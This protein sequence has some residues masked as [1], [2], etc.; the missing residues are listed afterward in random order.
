MRS[1]G[2]LA[3]QLKAMG[4]SKRAAGKARKSVRHAEERPEKP[5]G[6]PPSRAK[7]EKAAVALAEARDKHMSALKGLEDKRDALDRQIAALKDKHRREIE[8]LQQRRREAEQAYRD[9]LDA[10]SG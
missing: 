3:E 7:V 10:W 2:G 4:P 6:K 8:S 5:R 1:R 9:A